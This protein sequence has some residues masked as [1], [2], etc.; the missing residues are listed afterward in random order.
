MK[1]ITP[2]IL[3]ILGIAVFSLA[4]NSFA[5]DLICDPQEGVASYIVE[6][7]GTTVSADAQADGSLKLNV[8]Y[9]PE[10]RH[11]FRAR[12][13][14]DQGWPSDWSDPYSALKPMRSNIRLAF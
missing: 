7:D 2:A 3:I 5:A 10:G 8:D 12:A 11:I 1:K 6:I 4:G 14:S 9:L 13:I